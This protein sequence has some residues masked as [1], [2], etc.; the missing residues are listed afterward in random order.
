MQ[1][2]ERS[3]LPG[4]KRGFVRCIFALAILLTSVSLVA[5]QSDSV[6]N[7][8]A[9]FPGAPS[10]PMAGPQSEA[11]FSQQGSGATLLGTVV[12]NQG[13]VLQGAEVTLSG[14]TGS[15]A[16]T[17]QSGSNGQFEFTGLPPSTYKLTATAPG[18]SAFTS[19]QLPLA[20]GEFKIL[21]PVSLSI[22][23]VSTTVTVTGKSKQLSEEQVHI[24]EKQRIF[25]VIPNFYS[26][27]NWNAPPMLAKQKFQ[28][29][30]RSIFDPIEFL[31]VAGVAGAEQYENVFPDYG[32]GI[33][34]YGKRYGAA[35]ANVASSILL[36][37][38]VYPSIFHEDPR[39]FYM[40]KRGS[41]TKRA[42][43]A[44]AA[45]VVARGDDGRWK[46]NYS[47]VLGDFSA[48]A[49]S[50]L[51]YPPANRGAW[52]V[53]FNGLAGVGNDAASNLIREFILKHITSHAPKGTSGKP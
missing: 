24:A 10:P 45:A 35:F 30:L 39:Y 53:F 28:L 23:P 29:S 40:G 8:P 7:A 20:A 17:V 49:V 13:H 51:Y 15:P 26:N 14:P 36:S 31:S 18:M 11:T 33:E 6:R 19:A 4:I 12:D 21:P 34:G 16:Q 5:Q 42:L 43:Y 2:R 1:M 22:A 25:A 9:V 48:A 46:P 3:I 38:A 41:I 32:S 37:R 52:L 50:N 44:I 47:S 27:Y